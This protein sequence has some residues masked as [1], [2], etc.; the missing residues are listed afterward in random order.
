VVRVPF[1]IELEQ[2]PVTSAPPKTPAPETYAIHKGDSLW[3]VLKNRYKVT[4]ESM[5]QALAAVAKANPGIRDLNHLLV[6]QKLNI[7]AGVGSA[8][9][10]DVSPQVPVS[11]GPSRT[12]LSLL[13]ELGCQVT[14]AGE[15][16][17][18]VARGRTVRLDSREFPIVAGPT[19][20]KVVLDP[21]SRLSAALV[22]TLGQ[23]W[24][25]TVLQ[26]AERETGAFLEKILPRLGFYDLSAG[27]RRVSPA[28]GV[29]LLAKTRWTV[30]PREEDLWE[31]RVH[32]IFPA[33]ALLSPDVVALAVRA[34]YSVH[35]LGDTASV[36][37]RPERRM[38]SPLRV[39]ELSM[40]D[41]AKGEAALL[42]ALGVPHRVRPDVECDLGGGVRYHLRPE[43][44]FDHS[45]TAYAI[46]PSEPRRAESLL[47]RAGFFTISFAEG[48]PPLDRLGD[49]LALLGLPPGRLTAEVPS[50]QSLYL[51]VEG[52]ALE[53]RGLTA[54]LY[55]GIAPRPGDRILLTQADIAPD[56]AKI[57]AREGFLAWVVRAAEEPAFPRR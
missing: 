18:P 1:K 34:G 42:A 54:R 28:R 44:T 26:G 50:G 45:G 15:A 38:G 4:R 9:Q 39:P 32:L 56:V 30:V 13:E 7:P 22:N 6:G 36:G 29:E 35:L 43:V 3:R 5:P 17:L 10:A 49:L 46:P 40:V 19:G 16:F 57:L 53:A 20:R 41:P 55:P 11:A 51:R 48:S 24:N 33:G 8:A 14:S 37:A 23:A 2:A 12:V 52:L 31:G 27:S 21:S 25:Y 47:A